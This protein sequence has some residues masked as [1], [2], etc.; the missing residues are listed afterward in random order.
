VIEF[1]TNRERRRL[2]LQIVSAQR[3]LRRTKDWIMSTIKAYR[4]HIYS[5]CSDVHVVS[6][7]YATREVITRLSGATLIE[8]SGIDI[9]PAQLNDNGM[10]AALAVA[11]R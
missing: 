10:I 9:D 6:R 8:G 2:D 5:I 11:V 4:F 3:S 7:S 1:G